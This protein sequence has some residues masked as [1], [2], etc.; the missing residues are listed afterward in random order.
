MFVQLGTKGRVK[1]R[2]GVSDG[3][4]STKKKEKKNMGI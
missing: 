3:R 1:K 4:F 2:G